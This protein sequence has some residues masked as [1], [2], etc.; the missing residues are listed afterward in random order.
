[1]G[2]IVELYNKYGTKH[3][4]PG[5]NQ[6]STLTPAQMTYKAT[7]PE[8][9]EKQREEEEKEQSSGLERFGEGVGYFFEKV[10]LGALR[11]IEGI[12]DFAAGG[13]A[14]IFG[15]DEWAEKQIANDWVNYNHADEWFEPRNGFEQFIG[16]LGGGI[17]SSLPALAAVGIAAGITYLTGG[18]AAGV[19]APL[20]ST[21]TS[22]LISGVTTLLSAG[23]TAVSE[24]YQQTGELTGKEWGYGLLSGATEGAIEAAS[25][26]IGAGTGAIAKKIVGT[27]GKTVSSG[28]MK[29]LG[30]L[31]K[32][33]ISEAAEEGVME[34]I[35]PKYK[36]LTYDPNAK[37]AT[38]QEILYSAFIGGVSGMVMDGANATVSKA[39]DFAKGAALA[40][41][42]KKTE[43]VLKNARELAKVEDSTKTG[44][45]VMEEIS[46]QIKKY[47]SSNNKISK[48]SLLGSISRLQTLAFTDRFVVGET[49]AVLS[50]PEAIVASLPG[51]VYTDPSGKKYTVTKEKL[52]EG[53]EPNAKGKVS[54]KAINNALKN[55]ETLRAV[56]VARVTGR[57]L[58]NVGEAYMQTIEGNK[59]FA[60]QDELNQFAEGLSTDD[61]AM[62]HDQMGID[63]AT[64]DINAVN[65]KIA[66]WKESDQG[67]TYKAGI[68]RLRAVKKLAPKKT[69][70]K[71]PN[72]IKVKLGES[73]RY[74]AD[75]YDIAIE[76]TGENQY[77]VHDINASRSVSGLSREKMNDMINKFRQNTV[78]DT[79]GAV[80]TASQK[81][82]QAAAKA[83]KA[84]PTAEA[85]AKRKE[86]TDKLYKA[87]EE[88]VKEYRSLSDPNKRAV[89]QM[90]RS[91]QAY[92][93]A[94][95]EIMTAAKYMA[96]TGINIA[97]AKKRAEGGSRV[98]AEYSWS[99][100][101]VYLN[102]EAL[103]DPNADTRKT[104]DQLVVHETA[105]ALYKVPKYRKLMK[106]LAKKLDKKTKEEIESLYGT[107]INR[108]AFTSKEDVLEDEFAAHYLEYALNKEGMLESLL[109]ED[110]SLVEALKNHIKK[111][112]K[113]FE[114]DERL[115]AASKRVY[116][117]FK[118]ALANF[119]E[120]N[121]G[122]NAYKGDKGGEVRY[123]LS[124]NVEA[125]IDDVLINKYHSD[126]VK[127]TENTPSILLS[128][129]GVKNLPLFMKPSH[130]R[131][132][133]LSKEDAFS[134]GYKTDDKTNYHGLGKDK[135]LEVIG[136]L[137]NV[138]E[139]Y[140]G[141]KN[142]DNPQRRE[143]HFL[144][145]SKVKDAENNII[146]VPI[147][148]NEY[149][150]YHRVIVDTNKVATVFG[151]NELQKYIKR[152]IEKGN[153][154]RIKIGSPQVSDSAAPIAA[155]SNKKASSNSILQPSKKINPSDENSSKNLPTDIRRQSVS[156]I[157]STMS[158]E[159]RY[160]EIKDRTVSAPIYKGQAEELIESEI[161]SRKHNSAKKA[162]VAIAEILGVTKSEINFNDIDVKVK[163]SK[164]NVG[165][166]LSKD[167]SPKQIARLLPVIEP[168]AENAVLVERHENR[169]YYD[170]DTVYF[171]NLI[172]GY[173]NG[174]EFIPIRFG[175]K[176]SRTGTTTLYVVVDQ[177]AIDISNLTEI[178][179]DTGRQAAPP[180]SPSGANELHRR[181]TYSIAQIIEFV[182]SEDLLRYVPDQMLDETQKKTKWEGIAKT[183]KRTNDKNDAK[184]VEYISK[185][186]M[187]STKQM[188]SAAAKA[189]GYTD[190]LYHGA[191]KGG[192]FKVFRDWS[193]FTPNKEYATRYM[194]RGNEKSLYETFVK[195]EKPFDTRNAAERRIFESIRQ[196][197]GLSAIQDSGLPD[198]TD[199][200][201]ISDYIDENGLDYD[202]II[203]DEGGDMVDGKPV[204]R[205]LSYVVRK[206]AQIKSADPITYDNEGNIIPLS[207]RFNS[208]NP[209]IR[210]SLTPV[211][212][213]A[214][215]VSEDFSDPAKNSV[216]LTV[217][218]DR[219][220]FFAALGEGFTNTAVALTD[221]QAGI[222]RMGRS[223]GMTRNEMETSLQ[224][225]RLANA[226]A[227]NFIG[228]NFS[229]MNGN[230]TL[231]DIN[232]DSGA[233][234]KS[235]GGVVDALIKVMPKKFSK[236]GDTKAEQRYADF[237]LVGQHLNNIDRMSLEENAKKKYMPL[238]KVRDRMS[239][240]AKAINDALTE[241]ERLQT[242]IDAE[243]GRKNA[244]EDRI[245][246]DRAKINATKRNIL[247]TLK[248]LNLKDIGVITA[249]DL[250]SIKNVTY[251]EAELKALQEASAFELS[252]EETA[253]IDEVLQG[254][255]VTLEKLKRIV[256]ILNS[257]AKRIDSQID[258]LKSVKNKPVLGQIVTKKEIDPD[259][260]QEVEKEYVEPISAE[261]SRKIVEE[262]RKKYEGDKDFWE[263]LEKTK[264]YL[265][266]L[267]QYRV[268]TGLVTAEMAVYLDTIYP[269]YL[270]AY[271]MD[272]ETGL[273]VVKGASA[274][275]ISKTV[276]RAKGS[277]KQ[278]MPLHVSMIK[279]TLST[280][281]AGRINQLM[282]TLYERYLSSD[283]KN[284]D[285]YFEVVERIPVGRQ[286]PVTADEV[287]G[288]DYSDPDNIPK[289]NQIT[290]YYKGEKVT[291][292]VDKAFF[293]GFKDLVGHNDTLID[294]F[295]GSGVLTKTMKAF[296]AVA[297]NYN[298]LF[299]LRNL[300][301]D[302]A[303]AMA[304]SNYPWYKFMLAYGGAFGKMIGNS[305]NWK[306]YV[307][308]GGLGNT[309]FDEK[310]FTFN[311]NTIR[312][313]FRTTKLNTTNVFTTVGSTIQ[314]IGS[315]VEV[316]NQFVEQIPRFAAFNL[317][318]KNGA[319][320]A[321]AMSDAAEITTNFQRGGK[322]TKTF[323]R[324]LVPFLN[325][326]VQGFFKVPRRVRDAHDKEWKKMIR[327][328][329]VLL[330]NLIT[331]G[332]LPEIF[333]N[334]FA[335]DKEGYDELRTT[336]R[337]NNYLI[338]MG[339]GKFIKI[340]LGRIQ[341]SIASISDFAMGE[342]EFKETRSNVSSQ[343]SPWGTL[344][345][346]IFSPIKDVATNTTWYGGKIEGQQFENVRPSKRY[347][348][349]TSSISK[350]IAEALSQVG[351]EYSPKKIDYLLGQY[352]GFFG[353]VVLD[354]T[355]QKAKGNFLATNFTVDSVTS[356]KLS[357]E[358]YDMYNDA[359]YRKNE[360][361]DTA[362]YQLK[363]LN[364]IKKEIRD[365]Y[366][367]KNAIQSDESLSNNEKLA[368]T[369]VLQ[370]Y[371]N[372]LYRAAMDNYGTVT[373][374]SL[375]TSGYDLEENERFR[376]VIR[377][378]FGAE[379]AF[380]MWDDDIYAKATA[381]DDAGINIEK[382]YDF[383]F[384][385]AKLENDKDSKGNTI[386]GSKRA[387]VLTAIKAMDLPIE[388]QMLLL[389][390][391]GYS[392]KDNDFGRLSAQVAKN[393]LLRYILS[394]KVSKAEKE[395][396]AEACGFKVR[397]GRIVTK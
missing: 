8:V 281:R 251:T 13:I 304:T 14:D 130:I 179:E 236:K 366:D 348:E 120:S 151:K 5:I 165:E 327:N 103:S 255:T 325:A 140:R 45:E 312:G 134:K 259:T 363:Y 171:D 144:L 217:D 320:V 17:G 313:G 80:A 83:T 167:A 226:Q 396:I 283:S 260:K 90:V 263:S 301:K 155:Q 213:A 310:N 195:M 227:N 335:K 368:Q 62:L 153:I 102:V 278:L 284:K 246:E 201:D 164:G 385:T 336:D 228:G 51:G 229:R 299:I 41:D 118:K 86:A 38:A 183:I 250:S 204:S 365:L 56:I 180:D 257:N 9:V 97:F 47:D 381:F 392:I 339:D 76:H 146:N 258:Q 242:V 189:N 371:I 245:K 37:D 100:D 218:K 286:G 133:I 95:A 277:V 340:P 387:K 147:Y 194:E 192:G 254:K 30:N 150:S 158:E 48:T 309:Y 176:H 293:E 269:N 182:N 64:D 198:W 85:L 356:N 2:S 351:I 3:K 212:P 214:E 117:K 111:G 93:I 230:E 19:A 67:K 216:T 289:N 357:T 266:N 261:E 145:I 244:S 112:E 237:Q 113:L 210:Y 355:T 175:L 200:Y 314:K 148:I 249:K 169:Y 275:E 353:D 197:Y 268:D 202:G 209:D 274:K 316:A 24:A 104:F 163:L 349:S 322:V 123:A 1:M 65:E 222:T 240:V 137:D 136:D 273:M 157:T 395:R 143:K 34:Y 221:A 74:Q 307:A 311:S 159:E 54:P 256:S 296:R 294:K 369:R 232:N 191:K 380:K 206:S 181:V 115:D 46:K 92:G 378:S 271:R 225:A 188:V 98:N 346:T 276:Q 172:S 384:Y 87:V 329:A 21:G 352:T 15:A 367:Q 344:T 96:K 124:K 16:D 199:G 379:A 109:K 389:T 287:Y 73:V 152:E 177:N 243:K 333:N 138:T 220:S 377:L 347:D 279:Q 121:K 224:W 374:A 36:Q 132:N 382:Y 253:F 91:A 302:F 390:S 42:P 247:S 318:L 126:Y 119:S 26:G 75:G 156:R 31:G 89:R 127:L 184:Y 72:N 7:N 166:S 288:I 295:I 110:V 106:K 60:S 10:G 12:V 386:A 262:Y 88:G 135:F 125:E 291:V 52:L 375:E 35:Q 101:T 173:V 393:R 233:E 66:L 397:N 4:P 252:P 53:L 219:K 149:A 303:D 360:D 328:I 323:N 27:G 28:A 186:D 170:T 223:V 211:S 11:G 362:I 373:A 383:Y 354:A 43:E 154:V 306:I 59:R 161:E 81:P 207:Q 332:M 234:D 44:S 330:F 142:A 248:K 63:L 370:S 122:F 298:P 364:K 317:A 23:G 29:T 308:N 358:F 324:Y 18:A 58:A 350:G 69:M 70:P 215:G 290:F 326:S 241:I 343:V 61:Q 78:A 84:T 337:V 160:Q 208:A 139:A 114:G 196:E 341:A 282:S 105:H 372:A 265:R 162:V 285:K 345:R 359:Q 315:Y 361:D 264:A 321:E 79:A 231:K 141:T 272:N 108:Q 71:T 342:S 107:T 82:S 331:I 94:E 33:F 32:D 57:M 116:K 25:A 68:G 50:N 55:N 22:M 99:S 39:T 174:N 77:T 238:T 280:V 292:K 193:Y 40:K 267:M 300:R 178:K 129:K 128:Q 334:I 376:E 205:G 305:K 187:G 203:L 6:G 239:N 185:G 394:L 235:T 297:T 388:Q 20:L 319:T 391:R 270:P 131:E 338:P 190:K 168:A 49:N